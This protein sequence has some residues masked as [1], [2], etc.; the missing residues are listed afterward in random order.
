MFRYIYG[1][2]R[3]S[4]TPPHAPRKEEEEEGGKVIYCPFLPPFPSPP[5]LDTHNTSGGGDATHT[6]WIPPNGSILNLP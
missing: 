1:R 2:A 3:Y 5:R 4:Y 6:G